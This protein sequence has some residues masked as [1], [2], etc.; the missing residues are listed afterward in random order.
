MKHLHNFCSVI[1]I[2]SDDE[3]TAT[4][5]T[6]SEF[7]SE[8]QDPHNDSDVVITNCAPAK[9]KKLSDSENA[10]D[11]KQKVFHSESKTFKSEAA[12]CAN[13]GRNF[14]EFTS[15]T[16]E[17]FFR[18]LIPTMNRL[19]MCAKSV[20]RIMIQRTIHTVQFGEPTDA[21]APDIREMI[22]GAQSGM[23][24]SKGEIPTPPDISMEKE[25]ELFC[26]SLAPTLREMTKEK[27]SLAK[28]KI[29]EVLHKCQF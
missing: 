18:S 14:Y 2:I 11:K 22:K 7:E 8:G 3:D 4:E 10:M 23:Q 17:L 24:D 13:L 20:A 16:S 15:D 1:I 28:F 5:A 29:Q 25:D 6:A 9:R 21:V 27:Q 12:K 19:N 26:L